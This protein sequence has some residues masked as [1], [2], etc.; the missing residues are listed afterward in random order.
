[1]EYISKKKAVELNLPLKTNT[2]REDGY[3]FQYYY[4]RGDNIYEMWNSPKTLAKFGFCFTTLSSIDLMLSGSYLL[5]RTM[6][7]K[8]RS[9]FLLIG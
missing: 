2:I 3:I 1:M 9:L 8:L 6:Q 7:T 4:R 5:C